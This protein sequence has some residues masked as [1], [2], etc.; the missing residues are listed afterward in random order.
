MFLSDEKRPNEYILVAGQP[1]QTSKVLYPGVYN[2]NLKSNGPMNAPTVSFEKTNKY[3]EGMEIE[4][5]VFT[6]ARE[7]VQKF[8]KPEMYK[9]RKAM[10][11]MHKIGLIFDGKPG[12][13]KTFL[14]G[15]ISHYFATNHDAVSIIS[16]DHE[17]NYP[18]LI[19][20]IREFDKDRLIVIVMDE[21]EK[22]RAKY[23]SAMLSFLDGTD[24]KDNV[25]VIATINEIREMPS[26]LKDR[27][28]RFETILKF[29]SDDKLILHSI[30]SQCIPEEYK[31]EFDVDVLVKQFT[32]KSNAS[33]FG[34][35][36]ED[37]DFT[38]DRIR[39]CIRDL[40][41]EKIGNGGGDTNLDRVLA[42]QKVP[43]KVDGAKELA[44][45]KLETLVFE[46]VYNEEESVQVE[47]DQ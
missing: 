17:M 34:L 6:Q 31:S 35:K 5:G 46:E 30:I 32:S 9:A 26:Y 24:S 4:G 10:D 43:E 44:L 39:V 36:N 42:E 38:V 27:P 7:A 2:L 16:T 47:S 29:R 12:T 19:E 3:A 45:D 25:M 15:Q 41:A 22:S 14:A 20:Q 21:F 11:M 13:G 28:G 8:I 23:S 40:I 37:D 1:T 33:K 18:A